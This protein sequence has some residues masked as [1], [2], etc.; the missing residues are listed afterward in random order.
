MDQ[1]AATAPLAPTPAPAPSPE[2]SQAIDYAKVIHQSFPIWRDT[3]AEAMSSGEDAATLV[4]V[5]DLAGEVQEI[6]SLVMILLRGDGKRVQLS[7]PVRQGKP[8]LYEGGKIVA[9]GLMRLGPGTWAVVPSVNADG[10]YHG[11]VVVREVPEAPVNKSR[12]VLPH[13]L[14]I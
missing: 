5:K 8:P 2:T 9:F 11:H 3:I 1:A 14:K 6:G 4:G 7:A 10:V 12:L 13:D